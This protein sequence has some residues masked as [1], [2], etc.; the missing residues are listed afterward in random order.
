MM[1][2]SVTTQGAGMGKDGKFSDKVKESG[3]FMQM[4]TV[5]NNSPTEMATGVMVGVGLQP[6]M[7][8][9]EPGQAMTEFGTP[10]SGAQGSD[11]FIG[12]PATVDTSNGTVTVNDIPLAGFDLKEMDM[13]SMPQGEL[14][15]ELGDPLAP[16]QSANLMFAQQLSPIKASGS[17]AVLPVQLMAVDQGDFNPGNNFAFAQFDFGT[18]LVLDIDGDGIE[19]ISV[20]EGVE[21]DIFDTGIEVKTGWVSGDDALLAIDNNGNGKIDKRA[22]LFGGGLGEG[23]AK[24]ANFDSNDDGV[25]DAS[26]VGFNAL[27]V[28]QDANEDGVTDEGEL[29]PLESTGITSLDTGYKEMFTP[30]AQGNILGERS[31]A[32]LADGSSID[33]VDVYFQTEG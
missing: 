14:I 2:L 12:N 19:T 7:D 3:T 31:S 10:W 30:D 24:L 1:D 21:F 29:V 23:F 22:E 32:T 16:G 26:D 18:P 33:L 4:V 13:E 6:G 11:S 8:V 9:W 15:W 17:T 27:L 25:V 20:D 5:T 28:W